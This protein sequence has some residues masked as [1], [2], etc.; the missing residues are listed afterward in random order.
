MPNSGRMLLHYYRAF[1]IQGFTVN[2]IEHLP[3][4][5]TEAADHDVSS[6]D[7]P[8]I[9]CE[10]H[11]FKR[12]L[13]CLHPCELASYLLLSCLSWGF[14]ADLGVSPPPVDQWNTIGRI[15]API[16]RK[17]ISTMLIGGKNSTGN[18]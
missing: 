15:T 17:N 6:W 9:T 16:H 3:L 11:R 1:Y 2:T 5:F 8:P 12:M 10:A 18:L 4:G 7:F 14:T 13:H